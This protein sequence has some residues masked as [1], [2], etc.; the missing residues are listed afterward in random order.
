MVAEHGE[1]LKRK[2]QGKPVEAGPTN[3]HHALAFQEPP[4]LSFT[5]PDDLALGW[6]LG[7]WIVYSLVIEKTARGGAGLNALMNG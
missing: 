5:L 2:P 6:F 4:M 7:C 1:S 3:R